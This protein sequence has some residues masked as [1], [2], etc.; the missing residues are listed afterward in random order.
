MLDQ[1]PYEGGG[2]LEL[3]TGTILGTLKPVGMLGSAGTR[4]ARR[5]MKIR[6]FQEQS[7]MRLGDDGM[8]YI[9]MYLGWS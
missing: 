8:L 2:V 9:R 5:R 1:T 7:M 4:V 3:L 6:C